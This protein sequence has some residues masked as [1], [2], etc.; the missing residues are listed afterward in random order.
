MITRL[1]FRS[2]DPYD[3][4]PAVHRSVVVLSGLPC[5]LLER[6]YDHGEQH[7]TMM[8]QLIKCMVSIGCFS[9]D[10]GFSVYSRETR[11]IV[12]I[13][14]SIYVV[15]RKFQQRRPA[16]KINHCSHPQMH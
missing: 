16:D 15:M 8:I 14:G 10:Y 13:N 1:P 6:L 5:T 9:R 2:I 11:N 4:H 7:R 12:A 3:K